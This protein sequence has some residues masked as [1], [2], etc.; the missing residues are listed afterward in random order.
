MAVFLPPKRG[1]VRW[2]LAKVWELSGTTT[3]L[4]LRRP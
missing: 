4:R 3:A 1:A 2:V